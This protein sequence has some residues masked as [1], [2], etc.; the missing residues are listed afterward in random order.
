MKLNL[1]D[2]CFVFLGLVCCRY[3]MFLLVRSGFRPDHH[4]FQ[5]QQFPTQNLQVFIVKLFDDLTH[6]NAK[7]AIYRDSTIV[8][9]ADCFTSILAGITIFSILG[10]LAYET[11]QLDD[12]GNI[13]QNGGSGLAFVSYPE[14][15]SK[16][17]DVPQ[18]SSFY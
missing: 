4:L 8:S 18:V 17:Y 6:F 2:K 1:Y 12:I 10:N 16:F 14:A 3:A 15:I 7:T 11:G 9:F 5:L 13:V